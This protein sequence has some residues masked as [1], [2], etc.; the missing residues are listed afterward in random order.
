MTQQQDRPRIFSTITR[1]RFL[2][3]ED[4]LTPAAPD[5]PGKIRFFIGS[6]KRGSG[7]PAITAYHFLDDADARVVFADMGWGKQV[8][9]KDYK[10]S[11]NGD[12]PISRVLTIRGPK[13][14]KYWIEVQNGPGQVIG[15]GAVKPAGEPTASI[16][17]A[18]P[19]AQARALALAVIEYMTAYRVATMINPT[20]TTPPPAPATQSVNPANPCSDVQALFSPDQ[21]TPAQTPTRPKK[22]QEPPAD[23]DPPTFFSLANE[24]IAAGFDLAKLQEIIKNQVPW[25]EKHIA[26]LAAMAA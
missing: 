1:S 18:L 26:L 5:K 16:S 24:A 20:A 4:A 25:R 23:V 13:D 11:A 15:Q 9:I 7:Q 21:P 2:H 10:G 3:I 6:Y 14:G 22:A 17:I 19:I 12:Q 8:D